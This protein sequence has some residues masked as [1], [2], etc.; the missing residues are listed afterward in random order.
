MGR[1]RQGDEGK[2]GAWEHREGR[3]PKI[4]RLRNGGETHKENRPSSRWATKEGE[5]GRETHHQGGR[6]REGETDAC[7]HSGAH[8]HTHTHRESGEGEGGGVGVGWGG[9]E[10]GK[11]RGVEGE[12]EGEGAG[13]G[14]GVKGWLSFA[15]PFP[16]A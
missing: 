14:G 1:R 15:P 10:R 7:A 3:G 2:G 11:G 6:E 5:V 16:D 8:R 13:E 12:G 4:G 9:R